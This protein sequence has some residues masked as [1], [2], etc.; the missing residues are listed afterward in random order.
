DNELL[1]SNLDIESLFRCAYFEKIPYSGWI[2]RVFVEVDSS[3]RPFF[4]RP[5]P[6]VSGKYDI[7]SLWLKWREENTYCYRLTTNSPFGKSRLAGIMQ[8][9]LNQFFGLS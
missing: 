4:D 9:D 5:V 8:A 6:S 1:A 3:L 2:N 7:D